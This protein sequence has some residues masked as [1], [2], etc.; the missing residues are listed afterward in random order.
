LSLF[1]SFIIKTISNF[2]LFLE[3]SFEKIEF[4]N[5]ILFCIQTYASVFAQEVLT[6]WFILNKVCFFKTMNFDILFYKVFSLISKDYFSNHI[7]ILHYANKT[8][9]GQFIKFYLK[10]S[11]IVKT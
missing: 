6:K 10:I 5:T 7:S 9:F 8:P 2:L 4:Q 3:N 11:F 1:K